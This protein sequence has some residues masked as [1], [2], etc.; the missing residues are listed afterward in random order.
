MKF[1]GANVSLRRL[2]LNVCSAKETDDYKNDSR[3]LS[4]RS[5]IILGLPGDASRVSRPRKM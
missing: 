4:V 2:P 3:R 1:V 5:V